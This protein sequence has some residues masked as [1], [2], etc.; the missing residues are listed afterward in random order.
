MLICERTWKCCSITW[1]LPCSGHLFKAYSAN[2]KMISIICPKKRVP[3]IYYKYPKK[4]YFYSKHCFCAPTLSA[5][6]RF[7]FIG[8]PNRPAIN[9][10]HI[11]FFP[12]SFKRPPFSGGMARKQCN[13]ILFLKRQL[14]IKMQ[15]IHL[16]EMS[17]AHHSHSFR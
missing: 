5:T 2:W 3:Q 9:T 4:K 10:P 16:L 15:M 8:S 12:P 14:T 1:I 7:L 6:T 17:P 13:P 11:F